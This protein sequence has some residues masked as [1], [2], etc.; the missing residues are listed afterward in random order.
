MRLS[1]GIFPFLGF[2]LVL[3]CAISTKDIQPKGDFITPPVVSKKMLKSPEQLHEILKNPKTDT[4]LRWWAQ[5][6]L[7]QHYQQ[8]DLAKACEGFSK[9]SQISRFPLKTLSHLKAYESCTKEQAAHY[10]LS[11]LDLEQTP[12]WLEKQAL[13]IA[14]EYYD[15]NQIVEK[16]LKLHHEKSKQNMAFS[17]KIHHTKKAL[18]YALKINDKDY[19]EL[20]KNRLY[21]LSPKLNPKV[22]SKD[23][24]KIASEHRRDR[25]FK[26]AEKYYY[27]IIN[28]KSFSFEEKIRAYKGLALSHKLNRDKETALEIQKKLSQFIYKFFIKDK[29]TYAKAYYNQQIRYARAM[30]TLNYVTDANKLLQALE[31]EVKD[32][33][34]VTDI[35]WLLGRMAEEKQN[36]K[37][38]IA[39]FK[40][41]LNTKNISNYDTEKLTWYLAWNYR[42]VK[43]Y[44]KALPAF[45]S[46]VDMTSSSFDRSRYS[47]WLARTYQDL[48]RKD[49]A[50]IVYEKLREE[51]QLGYY[52]ILAHREQG[53]KLEQQKAPER[54]LASKAKLKFYQTINNNYVHWLMAVDE[55]EVANN[56][57]NFT[58]RRMHAESGY[59]AE[60]WLQLFNNF[61]KLGNH[62][63]I[64]EHL[65][66]IPGHQRAQLLSKQPGLLFP[67]PYYNTVLESGDRYNVAPEFIYSIMR[68]ESAF[69]PNARSHADAFGLMQLLP[70][71]A[72]KNAGWMQLP[73]KHFDD[74]YKPQI[75]IALGAAHLRELFDKYNGMMIPTIASYNASESAIRGWLS[76]RYR[77]DS[78]EF[79]EDIPYEETKTCVRL[80]LRNFV[81]YQL[82][83][84]ESLAIG[85][86]EW[87]LNL[88][89]SS[90]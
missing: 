5:F 34:P 33:V 27:K 38:A 59:G 76:T 70:E 40:K 87:T 14:L 23:Y 53:L 84:S 75:N 44:E 32:L 48:G 45:Q 85:F 2:S 29:K 72:E 12:K 24:L 6:K 51:D 18:N 41:G 77:G 42:K 54:T 63:S 4:N 37:S 74:L 49:E 30:W 79:I 39:W 47:Y 81:Y 60:D 43:D 83:T 10:D 20:L 8:T 66:K 7:S 35:Y 56:Y 80:V 78:I 9:L 46:I 15:K 13:D 31:G 86:P 62:L 11:E 68:Q 65:Y 89:K 55:T 25:E 82:L 58:A 67:R 21:K 19:A 88:D 71:L 22:D 52:G 36:F 50:E 16:A 17:K 69:D 73:Y 61:Q 28:S 90:S 3:G 26:Q 64:F 57:L 1:G